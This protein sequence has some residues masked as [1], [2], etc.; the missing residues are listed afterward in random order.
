VSL[1]SI[2]QDKY[3]PI[4]NS[5]LPLPHSQKM[6]SAPRHL[7]TPELEQTL[8]TVLASPRDVGRLE[9]IVVRPTADERQTPASILITP[10]RGVEG[11]H[12]L[13]DFPTDPTHNEMHLDSQV[14]L[15][16]ARFLRQIAV[17]E[18]AVCLAGDNLVVDLDLSEENL[19][20]GSRLAIGDAVTLE[21]TAT[22]HTGCTKLAARY[23]QESRAFMNNPRGTALHLR[24]R[25]ARVLTAG[26][27]T[28]GDTVRKTQ[29]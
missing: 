23:G 16:N 25:Y 5:P 15:M 4:P 3:F 18:E 27:A 21:I 11:D 8:P 13:S 9:V 1:R 24:G 2:R 28:I 20:A 29:Q 12:W 14:S 6:L 10:E 26:T 7:T 17:E 19:P 22:P